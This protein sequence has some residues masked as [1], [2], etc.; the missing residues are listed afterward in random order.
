MAGEKMDVFGQGE[1]LV[2]T[3]EERRYLALEPLRAELEPVV[4]TSKT[5]YWHT[6]LTAYFDGDT[7]VK[8]A[9]VML[10][11]LEDG[12]VN[13]KD[14]TEYDTRL[15]TQDRVMLLPLTARGKPKKLT[16]SSI[17]SVTP[18][19]CRFYLIFDH[20]RGDT[21]M[22]M[23]NLRG[24][25]SFPMGEWERAEAIRSITDFHDFMDYYM[26][27]CPAD[28]FQKLEAY[29][30]A[31]KVTVKYRAGDIF[32]MELDRTRY[33]Y[34]I[35]TG[36]VKDLRK[37][38]ELPEEHSL[39]TLMMVPLMVR[40]FQVAT[41]DP[42]LTAEQLRTFDLGPV[43]IVG[44]NDI[45]WGTHTI[46]DHRHLE[47]D[48]LQFH[49]VCTKR[50]G[51]SEHLTMFSQDMLMGDGLLKMG[52]YSLYIEWG[53]AQV[54]VPFERIPQS[55][56]ERLEAYTS[57]HGGVAMGI[58]PRFALPDGRWKQYVSY[59]DD[60]LAPHNRAFLEEIFACLGLPPDTDF[61][62]FAGACGGLTR[63][64]IL[65]RMKK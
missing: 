24:N 18:F 21:L 29:R 60:L 41:E 27:T 9:V 53:F 7:I 39:R 26:A 65:K 64:Q 23:D 1:L 36:V 32:R 2:L 28:Y 34:G 5:N 25:K 54:E 50:A 42:N 43:Q 12:T 13:Y 14:Y 19:G 11:R 59:R 57:P 22:G 55:L 17:Q 38:P 4:Y 40:F 58:D 63:G 46:V 62:T 45:I 6:R 56:R 48:D 15:E 47:K 37:L 51:R 3:N 35:I 52:A 49:F 8:V 44:D 16:A 33:C 10:R 31:P 20:R 30:N 61:D